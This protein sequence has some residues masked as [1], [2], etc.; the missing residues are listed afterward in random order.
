MARKAR[1]K[2]ESLL[3]EAGH[4]RSVRNA[5]RSSVRGKKK[6]KEKPRTRGEAGASGFLTG[7]TGDGEGFPSWVRNTAAGTTGSTIIFLWSD[8][9]F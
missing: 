6:R 3:I 8:R 5:R 1:W 7:G 9:K 2:G 4:L